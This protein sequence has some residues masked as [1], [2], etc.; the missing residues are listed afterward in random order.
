MR[1]I[2]IF[3]TT[4]R[5]GE[6]SPGCSMHLGE[7]LDIAEA[8]DKLGVDVI[9]AGFPASSEGEFKAVK[10]IAGVVKR[11]SVAV[12]CRCREDDIDK[13]F[14]AIKDAVHPRLHIFIATSPVHLNHK[15]NITQD[16][17]IQ[18]IDK[19]TRYA[20]KYTDDVQFS[21]EDASRTPIDFLAKCAQ[22]AVNAG[23]TTINIPDTTGFITPQ[24]FSGMI[25][26]LK[27]NVKGIDNVTI[28]VHCHDDLGLAVANSLAA[29]VVGAGQ[30]ECT[31]N[32]IGERA[33]NAPLEEIAMG[34]KTRKEYYKLETGIDTKKIYRTSKLVSS[35][36]GIKPSA[37]KA[38]IG[39]NA[40]LHESGIHQHGILQDKATYQI[41]D[42]SDIGIPE[43]ALVIG[44]HSGRHAFKDLTVEMGYTLTDEQIDTLF[45]KFKELADRK[46][47]VS[48][49][50]I[51]TL[52]AGYTRRVIKRIY[53]LKDYEISAIK[54]QA[55]ATITLESE[56]KSQTEKMTG[57]GPIDAGFKAILNITG[58]FFRLLDYQVHSITE[59][60]DALGE[61]IVKL[62]NGKEIM[63]GKGISTDV[64]EASLIAYLDAINKLIQYEE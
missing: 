44:K 48:R 51:E 43:N 64:M 30:I 47:D 49:V 6:Q 24:E 8:L 62:T 35:I 45:P 16:E 13:G 10:E 38:I 4:L 26:Y 40:F 15:L 25:V 1:K 52:L 56:G 21:F 55:S 17:C 28:S 27:K 14:D 63:T 5:D 18:I 20:K 9:E 19:Y 50:D 60:K 41:M 22:T 61:A 42:P 2:T 58:D 23:A 54:N 53:T 7:K 57:D 3:D 31:I 34:I 36:V 37:N 12:L 46:K 29:A 11:A 33:G 32:G 59:G 39:S